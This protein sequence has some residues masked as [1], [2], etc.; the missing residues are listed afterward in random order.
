MEAR[1][2]SL[3]E[4]GSAKLKELGGGIVAI[5][6]ILPVHADESFLK[7]A[8]EHTDWLSAGRRR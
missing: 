3:H 7:D 6:E 1:V 5:V 2:L 8:S 4:R